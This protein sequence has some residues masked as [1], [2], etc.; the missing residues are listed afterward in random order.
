M[1]MTGCHTCP[2]SADI[3]NGVYKN[4]AWSEVPCATCTAADQ[5]GFSLEF[6]EGRLEETAVE[7]R[8]GDAADHLPI[9]VMSQILRGLL[10][11]P[12]GERDVIAM[13]YNGFH[14]A[15]IGKLQG[16]TTACAEKRHRTALRRWPELRLLFP[17]KI[18]K[19]AR[20]KTQG[21]GAGAL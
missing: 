17:E 1:K 19:Q 3:A 20:R 8:P 13:R 16:V 11:L 2:T 4:A 18:A 15:A 21:K 10:L 7:E 14:Y 6:D 9:E 5:G 12:A